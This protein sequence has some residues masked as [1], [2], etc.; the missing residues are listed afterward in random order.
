MRLNLKIPS[1]NL[2]PRN[3]KLVIMGRE[4]RSNSQTSLPKDGVFEVIEQ[5]QVTEADLYLQR[6]D[7]LAGKSSE[8]LAKLNKKVVSKLDWKFLICITAMLLM[9]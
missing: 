7:L 1:T 5:A 4:S 2:A 9:K 3:N 8:E 6:F